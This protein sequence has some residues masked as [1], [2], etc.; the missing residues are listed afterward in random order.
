MFGESE[1]I[2][3]PQWRI[4]DSRVEDNFT[5]MWRSLWSS[6]RVW[7]GPSCAW[8]Q[9]LVV[10]WFQCVVVVVAPN[11]AKG[12]SRSKSSNRHS[13]QDHVANVRTYVDSTLFPSYSF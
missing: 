12:A 10:S 6:D 8:T 13:R 2:G 5:L 9:W 11:R 4:L 7:D 1:K 3:S